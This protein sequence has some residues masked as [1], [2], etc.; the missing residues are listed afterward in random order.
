MRKIDNYGQIIRAKRQNK[1]IKAIN[2]AK[3]LGITPAYLSLIESNQRKPD[4]DLLLR[5]QDILEL[6]REDL[7]KKTDPDLE[8]RTQEVVKISLLEDLDIRSDEVQEIVQLNPKIAKALIKLGIDHKNKELELGQKVENKIYKG[9]TTF[10]GEIVSDFIQKFENYFP[11][12]EEFSTKIYEKVKMNNRTRYLSLCSYLE[13]NHNIIVRDILPKKDKPFTKIFFPEKKEFYMSDALNLETKKLFAAALVAQL[14]A[15]DII[16]EYLDDF[17]FPSEPSRKV[18]KVALLNYAGAAIIMPYEIFFNECVKKH[19][20]DLELLQSTFAVSFEQVCHRVTCLNN[21]DPKLRGIP[22]HM[23]RVDRSGNVS[24]RFSLSGIEL[25][26]LSGACPKWNVYSAFSNPG[27]ISAAVSKMTDG[28]RY[29]CIART[30]EKGISKYG[31]E[32]GLLSIGLG[33]QIKYAKDFV[34]ADGLNLSDEKTE[35]KI[36]VS[37]RKCDRLD[38]SQR[39]FP[40]DTQ[41]YDVNINQRGVSIF[42]NE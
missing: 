17:S 23:I 30:V 26:R 16:E 19:R 12:L 14:E 24:K 15:D 41:S 8:T 3:E 38:C 31:E 27:K 2:L 35:S 28:E 9:S 34:Y 22:L 36:G 6:Q 42:V 25:P 18:T 11:K 7:T 33:C 13:K 21:P 32:K 20:Y 5:I 40:P 29:V 1:N 4:G 10:P 37:C 39:A